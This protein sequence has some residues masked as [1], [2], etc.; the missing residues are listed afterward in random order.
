MKIQ[1]PNTATPKRHDEASSLLNPTP[2][3]GL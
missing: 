1:N 3:K 2:V